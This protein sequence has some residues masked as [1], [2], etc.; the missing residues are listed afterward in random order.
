MFTTLIFPFAP[1]PLKLGGVEKL[2]QNLRDKKRM[3]V[4]GENLKQYLSLG[5]KLKK[6]RRG[7]IFEEKPFMKNYIDK[8]TKL[9]MQ[10][11]NAF[12]KDF[13]KL[14]NNSVFGKTMENIR[15]R[16]NIHLT[17]KAEEAEK[18]VNKEKFNQVKIFD[19]FLIAV[20]M[21]KTSL[22]FDKPIFVEMSILDLS[23]SL[24]NEFFFNFGKKK[25]EKMKMLYTDTD[26][27]FLE[28]QTDDFF[29]DIADDV[30]RWFDTSDFPKDHPSCIPVGKDKKVIGKFKDECAGKIMNLWL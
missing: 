13:F 12:E 17:K 20:K 26:T 6:I 4:H 5:L 11:K 9:R 28:I 10:A 3:V 23:K 18:L 29:A 30:E 7:L 16:V 15:K 22:H 8:N 2:T 21:K 14:M 27:L 1:E 19:E 25:W 24:M